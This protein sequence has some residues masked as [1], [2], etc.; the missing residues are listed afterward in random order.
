MT[1]NNYFRSFPDTKVKCFIII[2]VSIIVTVPCRVS[3]ARVTTKIFP[4]YRRITAICP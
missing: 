4:A 2:S 1:D 3:A